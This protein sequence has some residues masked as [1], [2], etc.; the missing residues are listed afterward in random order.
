MIDEFTT[1]ND[2][3]RFQCL[4]GHTWV[5]T[6]GSVIGGTGCQKCHGNFKWSIEYVKEV[7]SKKNIVLESEY[8]GSNIRSKFRCE[9]GHSWMTVPRSIVKNNT[10]CPSCASYGF[11]QNE[12]AW[13]YVLKFEKFIKYGI[14]NDL[15]QR[16]N[17][18]S[19]R[20]GNNELIETR[21]FQVG[22]N[23]LNLEKQIKQ[24][25]GGNYV[26]R[27]ECP[28]GYTETLSLDKTSL[29]LEMMTK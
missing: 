14:T 5:T 4:E 28:D 16:I 2:K 29:L 11:K 1:V 20:N 18:H 12:P 26:T 3:N 15:K 13:V 21:F 27:D 10:N 8:L 6:A 7:L 24:T 25:L 19:K 17:T 22:M 9:Q 23:A